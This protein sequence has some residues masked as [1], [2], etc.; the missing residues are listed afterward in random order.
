MTRSAEFEDI[1]EMAG[2]GDHIAVAVGDD[3]LSPDGGR[4]PV[5]VK[6]VLV[7]H[8]AGVTWSEPAGLD[9]DGADGLHDLSSMV[10][11]PGGSTYLTTSDGLVRVDPEGNAKATPLSPR[12]SAAFVVEDAVCVVVDGDPVDTLR[13]SDDGTTWAPQPLPGFS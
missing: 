9:L 6:Q 10:V 13:C 8:D 12:D 1:T 11:T 4:P 5:P 2:S 3:Y 7:S